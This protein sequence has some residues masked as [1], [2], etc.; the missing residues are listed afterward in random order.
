MDNIEEKARL[1]EK[2]QSLE[3]QEYNINK[4]LKVLNDPDFDTYTFT[5]EASKET[6]GFRDKQ[7][8]TFFDFSTLPDALTK[9]LP[10]HLNMLKTMI[11]DAQEALKDLTASEITEDI[12]SEQDED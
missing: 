8:V 4:L 5:V 7:K 6:N 11:V 12:E 10:S 1:K 2:I 9:S 3:Q